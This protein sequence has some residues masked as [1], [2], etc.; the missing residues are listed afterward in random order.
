MQLAVAF[1]A[2]GLLSSAGLLRIGLGV[3]SA[4]AMYMLGSRDSESNRLNDLKVSCSTY[5]K[6]LPIV[7]GTMRTTGNMIW[8]TDFEEE[9]SY[10]DS[11]GKDITDKKKAEKKGTEFYEYFANFA[12]ALCEGPVDELLRVWADGN[13]IYDKYN[14]DNEDLVGPG[15]STDEEDGGKSGKTAGKG[16]GSEG[17]DSGRFAFRFYDGSEEQ[18]QDPFMVSKEGVEKV[19]GYRGCCYI[20]FEH[21][22]LMDFGNRCPTITAEVS[23]LK[24]RAVSYVYAKPIMDE[25]AP[26]PVDNNLEDAVYVDPNRY[27]CYVIKDSVEGGRLVQVYDISTLE[28]VTRARITGEVDS[29]PQYNGLGQFIGYASLDLEALH[30]IGVSAE[31]DL[32]GVPGGGNSQPIV[33]LDPNTFTAKFVFGASSADLS[34]TDLSIQHA[35]W[36]VPLMTMSVDP[37]SGETTPYFVTGII[38]QF[39]DLAFFQNV[40]G[41]YNYTYQNTA[42]PGSSHFIF[43]G[44]PDVDSSFMYVQTEGKIYRCNTVGAPVEGTMFGQADTSVLIYEPTLLPA[45]ISISATTVPSVFVG[46]ECIGFLEQISSNDPAR[47]GLWAV[48]LDPFDGTEL[49]RGKITDS[50]GWYYSGR[51]QQTPIITGNKIMWLGQTVSST[52]TVFEVDYRT[53]EINSFIL[54]E[55]GSP[56]DGFAGQFQAYWAPGGY[57]LIGGLIEDGSEFDGEWSIFLAKVDKLSQVAVGVRD[58]CSGLCERVGLP[59]ERFNLSSLTDDEII[60]YIIEEPTGA[61]NVIEDL[62]KIFM[63]DVVES[64]YALKFVTRGGPSILT[65]PQEDLGIIIEDTHEPY[66]E[67]TVQAIDCPM[68]VNIGYVNP[69]EDYKNGMQHYKRPRSPMPVMHSRDVLEISYPMAMTPDF[70]KQ[71]AQK[72]CVSIWA[73]R[74][75]YD[76]LL[77]WEY[78]AYDPADVVTFVM[79]DGFSFVTRLLKMDLGGDFSI[80]SE[81]CGYQPG[82]YSSDILAVKPGHTFPIPSRPA[83]VVFPIVL[84]VPFLSDGDASAGGGGFSYYWGAGAYSP[85]LKYAALERRV[86]PGDWELMDATSHEAIYGTVF[87]TVP[88]PPNGP[89]ATDDQTVL[90]LAQAHSFQFG[91]QQFEWVSIPAANWPSEDNMVIIGDEVILFRDVNELGDGRVEISHLIRGWRGTE[92]A[93]YAHVGKFNETWIV[94]TTNG[95][96]DVAEDINLINT[97]FQFKAA[98]PGLMISIPQVYPKVLTGA[99]LKPYAPGYFN[100]LE[101]TP[102]AGDIRITWQRRTRYGGGLKNG[103]AVVPLNEEAEVYDAYILAAPFDATTF[104]PADPETFVRE[105]PGLT[106]PQ[107]DYLAADLATDGFTLASPLHVVVFQISATVGRGFPGSTTLYHSVVT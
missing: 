20:F 83:P 43:P 50:S 33:F 35:E 89:F 64:D 18:L 14:P 1:G 71:T 21:F 101:D 77:P 66:K 61:R 28:E 31:G 52:Y 70:A 12:M 55:E 10:F 34:N 67:T 68:T 24:K 86:T 97:Q 75:N 17:G 95:V 65:I 32:V 3:G 5:G 98:S 91:T 8:A 56:N 11:K 90:T 9:K 63:F 40:G 87:D 76:T 39:G 85:G 99:S 93:A 82:S 48:K 88:P 22:A 96:R 60:G 15:F 72:V 102:G 53:L 58:I 6:G 100:R 44:L 4:V 54:P 45:D 69:E 42:I 74:T 59:P 19:P 16:K 94:V 41:V 13:L 57:I 36:A 73:E 27:R 49:W 81:A 25:D 106:S 30:I 79:D 26:Q 23:V 29:I 38:S 80:E 37:V 51:M 7:F 105:F 107:L 78:L 92:N 104:D 46:A 62:T 103:T 84:D 47:D 2:Q